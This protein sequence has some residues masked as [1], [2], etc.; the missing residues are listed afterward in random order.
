MQHL[1]EGMIHSW[2]DGALTPE[3]S[4]RVEAHAAEC[5]ECAAAVAEARGFIAASSRIL[6][7]LDNA[8][9]GVIPAAVPRKRFDP[10]AWRIAATLL[11]VA[12]GTLVVV[13]NR[14]AD[15]HLAAPVMDTAVSSVAVTAERPLT[16]LRPAPEAAVPTAIEPPSTRPDAVQKTAERAPTPKAAAPA[17]GGAGGGATANRQEAAS[18]VAAQSSQRF[19]AAGTAAAVGAMSAPAAIAPSMAANATTDQ[20]AKSTS[21]RVIG[22]PRRLGANVTV[23]E[24]DGDTVT[25]TESKRLSV[26]GVVT[27]AA[28]ARQAQKAEPRQG[29]T[30]NAPVPAAAP[31]AAMPRAAD[32][33]SVLTWYDR[34]TNSTLT[35]TGRVS[36]TRLAELKARIERERAAA[37]AAAKKAP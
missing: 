35:L 19:G 23:Y 28:T 16:A 21:L 14:G 37:A 3:E 15:Q 11:V 13:R 5:P 7:S 12:A 33:T 30:L 6:T 32:S 9:R 4:A 17:I 24:I 25:L 34:V 8:P 22:Q 10:F 2:L 27:G 36:A 29:L 26:E 18:A 31:A 20:T 1:E